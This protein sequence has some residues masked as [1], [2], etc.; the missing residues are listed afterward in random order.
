MPRDRDQKFKTIYTKYGFSSKPEVL[1][2]IRYPEMADEYRQ[3]CEEYNINRK[4]NPFLFAFDIE[5]SKSDND[6]KHRCQVVDEARSGKT[7]RTKKY[8]VFTFLSQFTVSAIDTRTGSL[9]HVFCGRY[10]EELFDFFEILLSLPYYTKVYSHNFGGY[11]SH[12]LRQYEWIENHCTNLLA[13][14][15]SKIISMTLNDK[16]KKGTIEINDS[17]LILQKSIKILGDE[18][19]FPKLEYE[20]NDFILPTDELTPEQIEYCYRDNDI[21]LLALF[22]KIKITPW[23]WGKNKQTCAIKRIPI[24]STGFVRKDMIY[25]PEIN[26]NGLYDD[27]CN[28]CK[29]QWISEKEMYLT[30]TESFNGGYVHGNPYYIGQPI[31]NVISIDFSSDYPGQM[32]NKRYP[33]NPFLECNINE[34]YAVCYPKLQYYLTNWK[35]CIRQKSLM[36]DNYIGLF[37]F[38]KLKVKRFENNNVFPIISNSK[39]SA[40]PL[41][42]RTMDKRTILDNGKLIYSPVFVAS[43][44]EVELLSIMLTYDFESIECM[45]LYR[46]YGTSDMHE[47]VRNTVIYY[48]KQ[49]TLL[50]ML[51]HRLEN[52]TTYYDLDIPKEI[53]IAIDESDDKITL[54]KRYLQNAK[55]MLNGIYGQQ[56]QRP[57]QND[58]YISDGVVIESTK[59]L[60]DATKEIENRKL[61]HSFSVGIYVTAWARLMLTIGFLLIVENGGT[62]IYADTDSLKFIDNGHFEKIHNA[63]EQFN[64]NV[65]TSSANFYGFGKF[66]FEILDG[67]KYSYDYFCTLGAKKYITCVDDEIEITIAGLSKKCKNIWQALYDNCNKDFSIMVEKYFHHNILIS[68]KITNKLA[69]TNIYEHEDMRDYYKLPKAKLPVYSMINLIEV[70]FDMNNCLK[71]STATEEYIIV[72]EKVFDNKQNK[73]RV[74][75]N[76]NSIKRKKENCIPSP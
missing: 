64:N 59:N 52:H 48:G 61:N 5:T 1:D 8:K 9:T 19:Q 62:W 24:S 41:N 30:V 56:V 2:F 16:N 15:P 4:A 76:E 74:V 57:I 67:R 55:G 32:L 28:Q 51:V 46:S 65:I 39:C 3:Y 29:E 60:Y 71:L 49:K 7:V 69:H 22:N 31:K 54:A 45:K 38:K 25:N 47:L 42:I 50:K 6:K 43:F 17:L 58:Y 36:R 23:L 44:S 63:I 70:S 11:E 73:K 12:L 75:L 27:W 68:P 72:L 35:Q 26:K 37:I 34:F 21:S 13:N 14:S 10:I 18:L 33:K 20:Y 66:D 40:S 53:K